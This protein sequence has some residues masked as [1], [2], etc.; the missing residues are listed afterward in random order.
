MQL[1]TK[2]VFTSTTTNMSLVETLIDRCWSK[3]NGTDYIYVTQVL[4]LVAEIESVLGVKSF[5]SKNELKILE[6][7][8]AKNPLMKLRKTEAQEFILRLVNLKNFEALLQDRFSVSFIDLQR[9]LAVPFTPKVWEN[10]RKRERILQE[11]KATNSVPSR[12]AIDDKL[13]LKQFHLRPSSTYTLTPPH[14]PFKSQDHNNV[15]NLENEIRSLNSHIKSLENQLWVRSPREPNLGL[16]EL[17]SRI[18]EKDRRIATLERITKDYQQQLA[19]MEAENERNEPIIQQLMDGLT[20]QDILITQLKQGL[21]VTPDSKV[22]DFIA[23]LPFLKQYYSFFKYKQRAKSV[24]VVNILALVLSS[25]IIVN[26][27][28]MAMLVV[29]WLVPAA[30]R[31]VYVYDDYGQHL[32]IEWWKEIEWLDY[33]I[34]TIGDYFSQ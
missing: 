18:Q 16:S 19:K 15:T 6:R 9:R 20:K 23:N 4:Q 8:I 25:Y 17:H 26:V 30:G 12:S 28:R 29:M 32:T 3:I 34:Y 24:L 7:M 1:N 22:E 11:I 31:Q 2:I 5:L 13:D 27:L 14:T 10:E 33:A 21:Q